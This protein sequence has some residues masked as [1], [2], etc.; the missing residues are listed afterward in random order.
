MILDI[1]KYGHC[2][3]MAVTSLRFYTGADDPANYQPGAA[4]TYDLSGTNQAVNRLITRYWV[5]QFFPPVYPTEHA[6]FKTSSPT[7]VVQKLLAAMESGT[8]DPCILNMQ[9]CNWKGGHIVV[10]H[11]LT[12][13][14]RHGDFSSL[15][16]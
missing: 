3:G 4:T 1:Q 8:S 7:S 15:H 11:S 5:T 10:P 12:E 16:E 2:L 13:N 6:S 14:G 9:K